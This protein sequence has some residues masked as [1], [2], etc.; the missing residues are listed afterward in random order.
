MWWAN[1]LS[2]Y[3]SIW[4]F[5]GGFEIPFYGDHVS[6]FTLLMTVV[7]LVYTFMNSQSTAGLQGP[8]KYIMY[9]MPIMFL[10]F[11]NNYSAAL[12]F[13]YLLSTSITIIQNLVIRNFF[14]DEDK[15]HKKIQENKK[16]KVSVKKSKLQKR[17][18]EMAKQKG[19]QANK[20]S[21]KKR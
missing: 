16:K 7:T 9:L 18:E 1:D 10:G 13:Y 11:F 4:D 14:I 19:N 2:T 20:K 17:L 8:M 6:L 21:S 5:P 15:L 12:S 3:D